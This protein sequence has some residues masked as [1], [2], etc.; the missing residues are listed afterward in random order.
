MGW[1]CTCKTCNYTGPP[2]MLD[3]HKIRRETMRWNIILVLNNARPVGAYEE[4]MLAAM[5]GMFL[6]ASAL[7]VRREMDYLADRALVKLIKEPGGRWFSELT[8]HGIDVAEYTIDC[9]PGIG[10]PAKYW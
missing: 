6:D 4:L 1:H 5:Q 9:D 2:K 7:E 3:P 10:R 8:R